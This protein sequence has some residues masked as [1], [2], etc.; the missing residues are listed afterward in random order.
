MNLLLAAE[1]TITSEHTQLLQA[2]QKCLDLRDKY[3]M[4]SKQRLGDD[5]RDF[6]G[7]FGGVD[8]DHADVASLKFDVDPSTNQPPAQQFKP[9]KIYPK[10][11]PPA[12]HWRSKE[13]LSHDKDGVDDEPFRFEECEIPDPHSWTFRIDEKGVFQVYEVD[14]KEKGPSQLYIIRS[15]WLTCLSE[16]TKPAFDIPDIREYFMDLDYVLG[17]IADGPTKSFAFRRLKYLQ[18]KFTMYSL[19]N[20]YQELAD[21]KVRKHPIFNDACSWFREQRVP[22]RYINFPLQVLC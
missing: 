18:S 3:M 14:D 22:H 12:W 20:E 6:D 17:V 13:V 8:D 5:P 19:L 2:F 16:A 1:F 15:K 10:P 11:P 4:K 9:W 7:D 21:M